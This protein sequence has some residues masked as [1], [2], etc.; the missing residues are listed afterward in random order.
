M[1]VMDLSSNIILGFSWKSEVNIPIDHKAYHLWQQT[2]EYAK[3]FSLDEFESSESKKIVKQLEKEISQ[4]FDSDFIRKIVDNT[5]GFPWLVKKLCVHIF[6]QHKKGVSNIELY[7]Q[8]FNVELL[9]KEDQEKLTPD[10]LKALKFIATRAY[11][12][13]M[14]DEIEIND[15]I[16][17]EIRNSLLLEKKMIIKTGTKYNIYWDIFRDYLVTE[18]VPKVGETYILRYQPASVFEIFFSFRTKVSMNIREIVDSTNIDIADSTAG[19]CLRELRTLGIVIY[20]NEKYMLRN[21]NINVSEDTFKEIIKNKFLN[22]SFYLELIKITDRNIELEDII[23]IIKSKIKSQNYADKTLSIYAQK[24]I[25]WLGYAGIKLE[26][27]NPK[28]KRRLENAISFTPQNKP[29]EILTY[30]NSFKDGKDYDRK[31]YKL[32]KIL[33]DL[34]SLGFLFYDKG[35][36][37]F[38]DLLKQTYNSEELL[39]KSI[40]D[41]SLTTGKIKKAF[42]VY[43]AN[44]QIKRSKFKVEISELLVD[45]NS[46]EYLSKTNTLLFAWAKFIYKN[47]TN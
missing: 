6:D 20:K 22:H 33:Y 2:K 1:D 5:Q 46:K 13:N 31:N 26:N 35:K 41:Q 43:N 44:P 30:I 15:C 12:N 40:I 39:K 19:N 11:D 9:F 3:L 21:E 34:K 47:K 29:E 10:E 18:Q 38:N 27:I 25:T 36:I 4:K 24:F 45:I 42:E 8:D 37:I 16:S 28:F 14:V 23:S 7:N 32:M 17:P